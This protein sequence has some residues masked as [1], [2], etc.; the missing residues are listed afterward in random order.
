[1]AEKLLEMY[2][3]KKCHDERGE[4][5]WPVLEGGYADNH[6]PEDVG[7]EGLD[8]WV[9]WTVK[10]RECGESLKDWFDSLNEAIK[11]WNEKLGTP[12]YIPED[13]EVC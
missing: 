10:C 7:D 3:C 13:V 11:A 12:E 2:S 1:M 9:E 8:D 5:R 4:S 6:D